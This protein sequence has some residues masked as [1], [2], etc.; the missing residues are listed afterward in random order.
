M[1]LTRI[2]VNNPVFAAMM[3]LA[4]MVVGLFAYRDVGVEEFPNVEFPFV[5]VTVDYPGASPEVVESDL[6][7]K[8]EDSVNTISG[9]K[10]VMS[11][12]YE[13]RCFVAIEFYLSV[14]LSTAVQDVR[15]KIA[16][17]KPQLRDG[18]EE[19]RIE[20]YNPGAI[21]V[22]SLAF[23]STSLPM[24]ELSTYIEQK[25]SKRLQTVA[26]VGKVDVLGS[27]R[28][29][30]RIYIKPQAL[31]AYRVGVDEVMQVLQR[32][33]AE[34]PAGTLRQGNVEQVVQIKG[35]MVRPDDFRR[36]IVARR[37]G[38]PVYLEQ[39][40]EVADGEADAESAALINGR[41][42][43]SVDV[44]KS[45]GA[46]TI[47]VVDKVHRVLDEIRG[48]LPAG[49]TMT[50]VADS[51]KSIRASL[52]DVQKT[53]LE[54]AVLAVLIVLLFLGSWRST[55]ITG[56]TL[57][58]SLLGT[59]FAIYFFGFTI[60][61][62][63]LMALSLCIGLL[64]DDA[65]VVRENIVRHAAMGKSHRQAALEGTAEIGLAV[66]ATTLSIV[67]VFVPVA[68][69]GGIIGRFFYQ[70][71]VTV[72]AAVLLSMFVSFTLDPMLSS[73]WSDRH[74]PTGRRSGF[75][76]ALDIFGEWLDRVSDVYARILGWSLSHR[77]TTLGLALA[78]LVGAFML[79]GLIGKEFVPEPDLGE[80]GVKFETAVDASLEYTVAKTG[81][82]EKLIRSYPEVVSTYATVNSAGQGRNRASIRI[83]LKP[84]QARRLNQKQLTALFRER[85]SH[86]AGI[87]VTSVAASK[88]SVSGGLKPIMVS[89]QGADLR[90]LQRI[91]DTLVAE[92]RRIPGVVDIET[93]LKASK[94][95]I[96]VNLDRDAASD[97]GLSIAA[98][99]RALRPLLAGDEVTTWQDAQGENYAVRV[100][101]PD[102]DRETVADLANLHFASNRTDASGL[103]ELIPLG[104]VASLDRTEGAAKI[105]RRNLF[106]EVLIEANV[107]G[108][109]AGDIGADIRKV[110][111][112]IK[113]PPGYHFET[114]GQNK[115]MQESIGYAATALLLAVI[116]IYMVLGS[117]FNSFLFPVAIMT[118]L[119]L[120]LI[121][122]FLALFVFRST[123]NIFSIIGII[124]LMGLVT[125]NAILLIDFIK[126]RVGEGM[127]RSEAI[128][129]AGR[130][131]LRPILMTT[132]AMVM[133]MVP[134][135][136]GLGD[137]G[138]QRA[139]MAH[140]IIGGILTST[141]LTL[142]VVPVVYTYLDDLKAGLWRWLSRRA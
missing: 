82:V 43:V 135:A 15:D 92:I 111:E 27:V 36:L 22:V 6:T 1:W 132:M 96:A 38:A 90:Q 91:S 65:I 97:A 11:T 115:D 108:R 24:R 86:V 127:E 8:I 56:L 71:G 141:L 89:V 79:A 83:A 100:R 98:I 58:I 94:P 78:S 62:M 12:S 75:G 39:V 66:L 40:A 85:L 35:R 84:K 47:E 106:R 34:L 68:F 93:S 137:G 41:P 57:P 17:L 88:E 80:I 107:A 60:N 73:V 122:V 4:L 76:G 5:I 20:K 119:P 102:A 134:L 9:V 31:Q 103:P 120:S 128:L 2:S 50:Q 7:R 52:A 116:F 113:L 131:R 37:Q 59:I 48:E 61:L 142:I 123:L 51:S 133:G 55:V 99:G 29:E 124:M 13:G 54:G 44:I 45:S 136:L 16:V 10:K 32:E 125:K 117:Q 64:V 28:R 105:A 104:Q 81:Q 69:M 87:T 110:Q 30:V 101:L 42:A 63:T 95:G 70:F 114:E 138:E 21:P 112:R 26:G 118:S 109:P 14:P 121:G 19:P 129:Q 130:T 126:V 33:N 18:I 72:S 49:V 77:L 139:P 74:R 3:M 46:N 140:A 23:T 67:A 25:L 53:L